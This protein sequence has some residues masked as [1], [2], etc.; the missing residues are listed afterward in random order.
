MRVLHIL[1]HSLPLQSGYTFRTIGI[2]KEQRALGWQTWQLTTPKQYT[3][4]AL[5]EEADGWTFYRT[6]APGGAFNRLPIARELMEMQATKRRIESLV[7]EF[8]PDILHPHSP[9]LNGLPALRI[10]RKYGIPV[11]YEMRSSWED[12]GVDHGTVKPGGARYR[13]TRG[14]ETFVLRKADAIVTI[15]EG[16]RRDILA[17]GIPEAKVTVVPNAVD[18]TAFEADAPID[19]VL[20]GRLG[21]DGA[22]VLGF[23]GSF[24][25]Y[26]GLDLL[27]RAFAR[28]IPQVP[29]L[30]LLLV[31]GGPEDAHLRRLA[32]DLGILESTVFAGRVSH[33]E[34]GRYYRLVDIFVYPRRAIRLT[35]MVTPLKPLEAM[36]LKGV[37]LASD[38]GGH[39]E[40]ISDGKTGCLFPAGDCDALAARLGE[41]VASKDRWCGLGHAG[42]RFVE[43]ER[44]WRIST[45]RYIPVYKALTN[46]VG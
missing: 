44:S 34:I 42:R 22:T 26:E 28:V 10:G 12:A 25:A 41:L 46:A 32:S 45:A 6:L 17:R 27:L 35:E 15:C 36:A 18:L 9:I 8:K 30:K 1:D 11:V 4:S 39:K 33:E 20:S 38:V 21:L 43:Q 7:H 16:L 3:A 24:Y 29:E 2:L 19:R 31:G 13:L 23:I 37:V 5:I 14:L 40:L